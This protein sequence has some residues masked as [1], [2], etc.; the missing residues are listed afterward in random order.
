MLK[1]DFHLHTG[2]DPYDDI[3]Y[4]DREIIDLAHAKG[5]DVLSITNH[6][7]ITF[8][9]GLN[10]YALDKGILLLPGIELLVEKK[11]VLLINAGPEHRSIRDFQD[12]R[13]AKRESVLIIAPHP[14]FPK[15]SCLNGQFMRNRDI[16]DAV[17]FSH[18]YHPLVNFNRKALRICQAY[19]I[20]LI[21][22][23]DTHM[24][25]Q[26][27]KTS[28]LID[29]DKTARSIVEAV[30]T[31]RTEVVASPLSLWEMFWIWYRLKRMD[32]LRST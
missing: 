16:F 31:G 27:D 10:E 17:E 29:A 18:F 26:F 12:L 8:D 5:Y 25:R 7:V 6:G 14:F 32:S 22:S 11:H 2:S 13:D 15:E 28:T 3:A 30:R 20:P 4:S 1:A 24:I 23:S 9:E 21:G 19:G